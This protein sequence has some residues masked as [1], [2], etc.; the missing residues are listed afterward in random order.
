QYVA[1]AQAAQPQQARPTTGGGERQFRLPMSVEERVSIHRQKATD[2]ATKLASTSD[3]FWENV[4]VLMHFYD[5]GQM[6][7]EV[8]PNAAAYQPY[9]PNQPQENQFVPEAAVAQV[10]AT[11]YAH[12]DDDIPF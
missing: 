4:R 11:E 8:R 6:P 10:A 3:E 9:Q 2:V 12:T 1:Q 7:G 5:T